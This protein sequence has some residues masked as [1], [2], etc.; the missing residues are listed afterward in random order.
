[1]VN[2][3]DSEFIKKTI[4]QE[5]TRGN[6]DL[7]NWEKNFGEEKFYKG[8]KASQMSLS[9]VIWKGYGPV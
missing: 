7:G 6:N 9:K 3:V 1:M 8:S 5:C 4:R 2:I